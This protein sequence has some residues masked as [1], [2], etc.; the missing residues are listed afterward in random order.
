[1]AQRCAGSADTVEERRVKDML[2][3]SKED[4]IRAGAL[5]MKRACRNVEEAFLLYQRKEAVNA[6][7]VPVIHEDFGTGRFYSLPA[8]VGGDCHMAGLKWTT[9]FPENSGSDVPVSST[10]LL[11]GD[12]KTGEPLAAME[13]S[14]LSSMR[15]GAVTAAALKYLAAGSSRKKAIC[16]GAGVQARQQI[17]AACTQLSELSEMYV[18]GRTKARAVALCEEIAEEFPQIRFQA[19]DRFEEEIRDCDLVIAATPAAEPYLKK[20]HFKEGCLYCHIGMNEI[21]TE[22]VNQFDMIVCDDFFKGIDTSRQSLFAAARER[23][24]QTE[25][26]AGSLAEYIQGSRKVAEGY[27]GRIMFDA[28][29]LPI[30]DVAL[31]AA[32]YRYALDHQIGSVVPL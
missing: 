23:K 32:V 26:L 25:K 22:A 14:I 29:G 30:F 21:E 1:M 5:D 15:T 31:G 10:L 24:L 20:E 28:F 4:V 19:L 3:L 6:D 17:R 7:E 8:Y 9:L 11:L 18:W 16:C 13:G 27:T 2:W 12:P